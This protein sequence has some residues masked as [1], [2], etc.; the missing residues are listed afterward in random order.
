M[1]KFAY[2]K[3]GTLPL[4]SAD[5]LRLNEKGKYY[6]TT[7]GCKAS[8]HTRALQS[9][10]ACFVS[11]RQEAHIDPLYCL[12]KDIFQPD[13]YDEEL[14]N[15]DYVFDCMLMPVSKRKNKK[16][17][18]NGT[19]NF[20]NLPIRTLKV[21]YEMCL[22]Y[23]NA[24][25]NNYCIDDILV[26]KYNYSRYKS[27]IVGRKI[28]SCTFYKYNKKSQSIIMNYP[29]YDKQRSSLVKLNVKDSKLFQKCIKKLID[30]THRNTIIVGGNW[31]K[32]NESEILSECEIISLGK[33]V[34]QG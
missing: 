29:L 25:Y 5:S 15:L 3:V 31:N 26:D 23:K 18:E 14:F 8:M 19:G 12:K 20:N 21:L 24:T 13:K 1:A 27:G 9:P 33:Q 6:C 30:S 32:S 22:Q 11:D 16:L 28:V 17:E 4:I 2:R 34:C 7:P 10:S